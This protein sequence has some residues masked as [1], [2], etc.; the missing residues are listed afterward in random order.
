[1]KLARLVALVAAFGLFQAAP[2]HAQRLDDIIEILAFAWSHGDTKALAAMAARDGISIETREGRMG[3][4]RPRQASAVLRRLLDE[5]ET[6]S[7]RPGVTQ[8]VGGSP[9]RA[10]SE[11]RWVSRT[12]NT[13]QPERLTI[14]IELVH[15][16]ERWRITQIRM[17]P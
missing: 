5:R 15:E 13:N 6:V 9:R 14:F 12:P 3:P 7:L 2:A 1:V 4:L 10:F 16:G 11:L 8:E 17:L